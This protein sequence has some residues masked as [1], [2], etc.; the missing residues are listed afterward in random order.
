MGKSVSPASQGLNSR[1]V[2]V[3]ILPNLGPAPA[4]QTSGKQKGYLSPKN[5]A[6]LKELALTS[7]GVGQL[8]GLLVS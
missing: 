2:E 3:S 1:K 8:V 6:Q 7:H 4:S 5:I